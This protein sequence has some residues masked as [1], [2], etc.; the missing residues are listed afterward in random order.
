MLCQRDRGFRQRR[1]EICK[2]WGDTDK[3]WRDLEQRVVKIGIIKFADSD[4]NS[5]LWLNVGESQI[6]T[7]RSVLHADMASATS[8]LATLF[9]VAWDSRLPRDSDEHFLLHE[10]PVCVKYILH[11]TSSRA[12]G[13]A[14]LVSRRTVKSPPTRRSTF[15]TCPACRGCRRLA[16]QYREEARF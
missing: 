6:N 14:S 3:R 1:R 15:R 4:D 7:R 12:G 13:M 5:T 10:S 11:L 2:V 8:M 16:L 9:D